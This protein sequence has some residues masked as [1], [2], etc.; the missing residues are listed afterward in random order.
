[1]RVSPLFT[2]EAAFA[3][4]THF[5]DLSYA[6]LTDADNSQTIPILTNVANK[7]GFRVI[8]SRLITPFV[9]S[10]AALVSTAITVGDAGSVNRDLTSQELNAA[11]AYITQKAGVAS[12]P[13][14]DTAD[15]VKNVTVTATA[16]HNLNTHTAGLV[17]IYLQ[18]VDS[19]AG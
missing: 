5:A 10:D 18:F 4:A 11:G 14:V 6:D 7:T 12:V 8:G 13:L 17:R 1:M 16:A 9:S 2:E 3:G 19:R 15:T